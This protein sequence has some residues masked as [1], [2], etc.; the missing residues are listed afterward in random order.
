MSDSNPYLTQGYMTYIVESNDNDL[1]FNPTLIANG[2]EVTI[3]GASIYN[4]C[5]V[6]RR[7][8]F[9]LGKILWDHDESIDVEY[10]NKIG[11]SR[12]DATQLSMQIDG[13]ENIN[14]PHGW[15]NE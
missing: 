1:S 9:L 7:L 6:S 3:V 10:L 15:E 4:E 13:L 8:A 5:N 2:K 12:E 11:F 14:P